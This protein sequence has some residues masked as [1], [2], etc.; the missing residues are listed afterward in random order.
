M[1]ADKSLTPNKTRDIVRCSKTNGCSAFTAS[2]RAKL[3]KYSLEDKNYSL[4]SLS[5]IL[6]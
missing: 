3:A 6:L 1:T 4:I 2:S 5:P